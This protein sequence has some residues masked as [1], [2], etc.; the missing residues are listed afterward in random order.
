[1]TASTDAYTEAID[2][3]EAAIR[4]GLNNAA[5]GIG[6]PLKDIQTATRTYMRLRRRGAGTLPLDLALHA[7][8]GD[9]WVT[10][11]PEELH[12]VE[13]LFDYAF[14]AELKKGGADV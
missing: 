9:P 12:H 10:L 4:A 6:R 14:E 8:H 1:M 2:R 7:G 13:D 5:E 11:T 3:V